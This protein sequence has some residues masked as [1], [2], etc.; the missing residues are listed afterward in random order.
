MNFSKFLI[1]AIYLFIL[2]DSK[3]IVG[4]TP[5][6]ICQDVEQITQ[7]FPKQ[8]CYKDCATCINGGGVFCSSSYFSY[9]ITFDDINY[10]GVYTNDLCW[11]G[12]FFFSK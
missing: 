8:M 9:S 7:Y 1:L 3:I 2:I 6:D 10:S 4:L 11:S 5:S 12:K